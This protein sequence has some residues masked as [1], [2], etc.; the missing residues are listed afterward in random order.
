MTGSE[1]IPQ[2]TSEED[3]PFLRHTIFAGQGFD[4]KFSEHSGVSHS[5]CGLGRAV[6][7]FDADQARSFQRKHALVGTIVAGAE[8]A[9]IWMFFREHLSDSG[10]LVHLGRTDFHDLFAVMNLDRLISRQS[11]QL[12]SQLSRLPFTKLPVGHAIVPHE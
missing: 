8:N 7:H 12:P 6:S 1:R 3:V 2:S 11:G 10:T 9:F 5:E 4:K